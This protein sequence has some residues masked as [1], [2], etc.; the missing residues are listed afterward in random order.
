MRNPITGADVKAWRDHPD[1][2]LS[3]LEVAGLLLDCTPEE[4]DRTR[5]LLSMMANVKSWEQGIREPSDKHSRLLR[6]KL[7]G[8][9]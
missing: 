9:T 8:L 3:Q 7:P 4:I 6:R 1:R 5:E 2:K